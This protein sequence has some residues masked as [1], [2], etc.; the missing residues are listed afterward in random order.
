LIKNTNQLTAIKLGYQS[1]CYIDDFGVQSYQWFLEKGHNVRT[2]GADN[3]CMFH[4]I[5]SFLGRANYEDGTIRAMDVEIQRFKQ[6]LCGQVIFR[7]FHQ[8]IAAGNGSDLLLLMVMRWLG[9]NVIFLHAQQSFVGYHN[10]NFERTAIFVILPGHVEVY[11]FHDDIQI[12]V[13]SLR[14]SII[15][16]QLKP[17]RNITKL[18]DIPRAPPLP[19]SVERIL[20]QANLP[21]G[22]VFIPKPPP[23]TTLKPNPIYKE[24]KIKKQWVIGLDGKWVSETIKQPIERTWERYNTTGRTKWIQQKQLDIPPTDIIHFEDLIKN[25]VIRRRMPPPAPPLPEITG[26]PSLVRYLHTNHY[27]MVNIRFRHHNL[28]ARLASQKK[29]IEA[30][31]DTNLVKALEKLPSVP[32]LIDDNPVSDS[33]F[34][35]TVSYTLD[36]TMSTLVAPLRVEKEKFDDNM[37]AT[38]TEGYLEKFDKTIVSILDEDGVTKKKIRKTVERDLPQ[39]S[40]PSMDFNRNINATYNSNEQRPIKKMVLGNM[41]WQGPDAYVDYEIYYILKEKFCLQGRLL[42]D[43]REMNK[44]YDT[45]LREYDISHIDVKLLHLIKLATVQA[46]FTPSKN[47]KRILKYSRNKERVYN[48]HRFNDFSHGDLGYGGIVGKVIQWYRK[49]KSTNPI[50]CKLDLPKSNI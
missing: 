4:A 13:G 3:Q 44:Y 42:T 23:I 14:S 19:D 17:V 21:R 48:L 12:R 28:R 32:N 31:I 41:K 50:L 22:N 7:E 5:L 40:G 27:P 39:W 25:H 29:N 46:A 37:V 2:Y 43:L 6:Q 34:L 18:P 8:E 36:Q 11:Q 47:E 49:K 45:V 35:K 30:I 16:T 26:G 15:K 38:Y 33:T 10:Y 1:A 20:F 24:F 9:Y